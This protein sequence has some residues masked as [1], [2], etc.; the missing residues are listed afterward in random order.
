MSTTSRTFALSAQ[1]ELVW[2]HQRLSPDSAAYHFTA[3][4]DLDG[5]LD[6][7][8]LRRSLEQ[9]VAG[10]DAFRLAVSADE[11]TQRIVDG[12]LRVH[13]DELDLRDATDPD[14]DFLDALRRHAA[15]LFR[16]DAAPLGRWLLVRLAEHRHRLVHSEHHLIHDGRSFSTFVEALF[17]TYRAITTGREPSPPRAPGYA[18]YV[19]HCQQP[20]YRAEVAEALSWW[21]EELA[22]TDFAATFHGLARSRAPRRDFAGGQLRRSLPPDLVRALHERAARDG[23]TP[24]AVLYGLF[25]ELLRRHHGRDDFVLGTAVGNRPPAFR[26]TIG[27]MVNSLP[28]RLRHEPGWSGT[29]LVDVAMRSLFAA[30][31]QQA[32]PVHEIV[33]R[34]GASTGDLDN[35]LFRVMFSQH[36]S[37]LPRW[38][39]PGLDVSVTEGINLQSARFDIDVVVIP[40]HRALGGGHT[41]AL[42]MVWDYS[43]E[44]FTPAAVALLSARYERL[45][46]AYL[47]APAAPV[48]ELPM[49]EPPAV[50]ASERA[51]APP[52]AD[53][54]RAAFARFGD[55]VAIH[56]GSNT[57][58]YA[59]LAARVRQAGAALHD[60]G[61][62]P[63]HVVAAVL[64]RGVDA[65]V[66]LLACL[67]AGIPF[68]PLPV[69]TPD[70]RVARVVERLR[71]VLLIAEP[72]RC[73]RL[74]EAPTNV[75][76]AGWTRSDAPPPTART[77]D[78]AYVIH[79][80]GSTG[81]PKAVAVSRPSLDAAVDRTVEAFAL[82]S[83]DRTLQFTNPAF[84]VF[85]EEVLPTLVQGGALV[86]PR[87]DVPSG[88]E[89]A[90][91]LLLRRVS[92][93]NLPTA[94]LASVVADLSAGLADR[95]HALRMIVVGGERL[96]AEL[97]RET[98]AIAP[99]LRVCNAYGVTEATITSTLHDVVPMAPTEDE[100]PI[101]R[102]LPGVRVVVLDDRDVP[103]PA[104]VPGEIAIGG[105][106]TDCWYVDEPELTARRFRPLAGGGEPYYRSGDIGYWRPDGT[107]CFVGRRDRQV[108][109]RGHRI[110]P[111]E[112][113]L[114]ARRISGDRECAVL[115]VG[116]AAEARLVGFV[117]DPPPGLVDLLPRRL[118]ETLPRVSVPD[119][120]I[121]VPAFPRQPGSGKVDRTALRRIAVDRPA[122]PAPDVA[123]P[124]LNLVLAA[125]RDVLGRDV[126]AQDD[127][128]DLGGHSL[129]AAR[130]AGLIEGGLGRRVQMRLVFERPRPAELAEAIRDLPAPA[131]AAGAR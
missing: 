16:L 71:P 9:V 82:T 62:R 79:T 96:P 128:F 2:L 105:A 123:D 94:Y 73:A 51:A 17:T 72:D 31:D 114:A 44:R 130:V 68:A 87:V 21:Q 101:G 85:L 7:D 49:D 63:G 122:P 24:F 64:P 46:R 90:A 115:L 57:L 54:L 5:V 118:G 50:A 3:V 1:Q 102:P 109:V 11:P 75:V 108:K 67:D 106:G 33:R 125:Y 55:A 19:R 38:T 10:H 113:E 27:M 84:D 6:R 117:E 126:D 23:H 99:G 34:L 88:A 80:S 127:F 39:V 97:A 69:D 119:Q 112:V 30:L 83:A 65:I 13:L 111:E 107:L 77:I 78:A 4:F 18:E 42:T 56:Q 61:A 36:D 124:V 22:G 98:A 129:L 110:E 25:A 20:A 91:L 53:R 100:V 43:T 8:A 12:D 95:D 14:A 26:H 59:D 93:L 120:W 35:P 28:V 15:Q 29:D 89:L 74:R 131:R 104:G 47:A 103:Q 52:V 32:A 76:P 41:E 58:S 66:Y 116:S 86:L 60:A 45:L 81:V 92:V 40:G 48:R 37:P 70:P 121:A